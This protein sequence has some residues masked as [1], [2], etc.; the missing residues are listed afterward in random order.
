MTSSPA[1]IVDLFAGAGGWDEGLAE[2]GHRA[3]GI[4]ND[5]VACQTAEAAGHRRS[6]I[7]VADADPSEFGEVWGLIGSPPCQAY[8]TAG[9]GGGR[10]DKPR[11]IRCAHL[12]AEGR[13]RRSWPRARCKDQGSLLTVEPLRWAV[14][15]RPQWIALEQVPPVLELWELFADL[16]VGHGY[17]CAVGVLSA[18]QYGVAQ[19]RKRAYL[20]ANLSGP[21]RLPAPTHRS[22]NPRDPDGVRDDERELLPWVS[23]AQA[24][25]WS[26]DDDR[27]TYTNANT[28]SGRRPRGLRRPTR[29]PARTLDSSSVA[30][31]IERDDASHGIRPHTAAPGQEHRRAPAAMDPRRRH[32]RVRPTSEPAPTLVA[33]GLAG[34]VPVWVDRRSATTIC[35]DPRV[36]PPGHKRNA[37]DPPG[38]YRSRDGSDATR[39]TVEQAAVLQGFRR[40]YPWQGARYRQFRQ[41]GN[42]VCP[43]V[44]RRV[45]AEAMRPSLEQL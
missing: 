38:C 7:D 24:L 43:P 28:G 40:D 42:A 26:R 17:H 9:K 25:G 2:L 8:S 18:E 27:V 3:I 33:S 4:E 30:W 29:C 31:T 11:V 36:Q 15:L 37:A 6:M 21:V 14:A 20:I 5:P 32:M 13:D 12:L 41:I 22:Y 35:A 39:V 44:A 23:M 19:T 1:T 16:L 34:G 10:V 45:L